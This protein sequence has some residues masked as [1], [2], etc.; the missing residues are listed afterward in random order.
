M[1][2][3][4]QNNVLP[5]TRWTS[6][7]SDTILGDTDYSTALNFMDNYMIEGNPS[8]YDSAIVYLEKAVKHK[9]VKACAYLGHLILYDKF[10]SLTDIAYAVNIIQY[11]AEQN[12]E[13]ANFD[14]GVYMFCVG[15][16]L[17]GEKYML[18]ADSLGNPFALYELSQCY[19]RGEPTVTII[20]CHNNSIPVNNEKAF[21]YCQMAADKGN[22]YAQVSMMYHYENQKNDS[23]YRCTI[24]KIL[25]NSELELEINTGVYDEMD[26][27]LFEKYGEYW[28]DTTQSWECN[29]E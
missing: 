6:E 17:D 12:S 19:S 23:E 8:S 9:H 4:N 15:R 25:N 2:T 10:A 14:M 26:M 24:L 1:R 27:F 20:G 18:R 29:N 7:S 3:Q 5:E 13:T 16:H 28:I 21:M 22:I 11:A